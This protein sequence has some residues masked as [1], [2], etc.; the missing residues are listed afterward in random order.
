MDLEAVARLESLVRRATLLVQGLD[1]TTEGELLFQWMTR[2]ASQADARGAA[3]VIDGSI[4]RLEDRLRLELN[5]LSRLK[6]PD[7]RTSLPFFVARLCDLW[8]RETGRR[9]TVNPFEKTHY[10]GVPQSETG[11]FVCEVV[12]TLNPTPA[13]LHRLM[14]FSGCA[15]AP[16]L[17]N[18]FLHYAF[19]LWVTRHLPGVRFARYA[20]DAVLHCKS[21][22]QAEYVLERIR[23]RF[24]ACNLEL[25]PGKTRIVYCKDINRTEA[26]P[27]IQFTFL[28]YTFRP[29]K[30]VDKYDRVYVN[31]SPAVSRDALKAMRQ[32]I[33]GWRVQLKNDKSVADLSAM[34][35]PILRGWQQYYG[36]FHGSALK[37]VWRRV[38][39]ALVGWLM[40]KHKKLAGHK[41][42]AAET[43]KRL[44]QRQPRAFV[45]WS[46]GYQS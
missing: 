35:G 13:A 18:L 11:V 39:Q 25:H 34:L 31:F 29:R 26:N 4:H 20:D 37:S 10:T 9:V 41:T 33:R 3:A 46:M 23:E 42:R 6:G 7:S 15:G 40:R 43:L 28:G 19:D 22:R 5:R 14:R 24:Q 45:H 32:T 27:D 1:T 21:R 44:A 17:A 12:E 8:A 38:N 30:A 16:I 36:H 2:T